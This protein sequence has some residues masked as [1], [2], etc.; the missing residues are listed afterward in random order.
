MGLKLNMGSGDQKMEG[1]KSVDISDKCGADYV[2]DITKLPYPKEWEGVEEIRMDNIIEHLHPSDVIAVINECHRIMK[3][4]GK[5]WIR[6]PFVNV[7]RFTG[8]ES[9]AQVIKRMNDI[10]TQLDG[11]MTD[12]THRESFTQDTFQYWDKN[13]LRYKSFGK[14]YGIIPW[15]LSRSEE[16]EQ[17]S[18][19]LICE[20]IR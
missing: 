19:F 18:K 3:P 2:Y 14:D 15:S 4:G 20:M 17:G 10:L 5:L 1:Y 7:K 12:P 6:V 11:M 9:L 8:E 13:H 16:W